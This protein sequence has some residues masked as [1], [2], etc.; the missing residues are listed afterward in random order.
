MVTVF[1]CLFRCGGD[2]MLSVI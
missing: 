1:Y 2:I